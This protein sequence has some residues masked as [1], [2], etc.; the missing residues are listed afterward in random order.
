MPTGT[1]RDDRAEDDERHDKRE[2]P[3]HA[4]SA[5]RVAATKT[6]A[7]TPIW[8]SGKGLPVSRSARSLIERTH[9]AGCVTIITFHLCDY[10]AARAALEGL[11]LRVTC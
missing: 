9:G 10:L 8:A 6:T 5:M 7:P 2:A 3:V 4:H 11:Y 1:Q